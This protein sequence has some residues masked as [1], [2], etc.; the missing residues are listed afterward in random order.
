LKNQKVFGRSSANIIIAVKYFV[1]TSKTSF[2]LKII[3]STL[4]EF[5][6]VATFKIDRRKCLCF[7]KMEEIS[8]QVENMKFLVL[9]T[10]VFLFFITNI[11]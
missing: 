4:F 7:F 8:N 11:D 3:H 6:I 5:N 10:L 2:D 1:A 9:K